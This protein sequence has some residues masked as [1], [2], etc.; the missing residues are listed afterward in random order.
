MLLTMSDKNYNFFVI[1]AVIAAKLDQATKVAR[2]LSLT[3]SNAR[4]VALRAGEGAAGFRPLTD[5]IDRLANVTVSSSLAINKLAA[6]LSKTAANKF[7]TD[8][9]IT[10]FEEVYRKA[11]GFPHISSLSPGYNRTKTIQLSLLVDYKRQLRHLTMELD[12][13]EDEL[14]TAVI[15]ATLSRV[16]ASQ[17]GVLYQEALNNVADNVE[18]AASLIKSHIRDSQQLVFSLRQE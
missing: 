16:E 5:F 7:R 4:A 10:R 3:A 6:D 9:A 1:A 8:N 13:L 18:S 11:E 12:T 17:A 14:R 15:L 2:L